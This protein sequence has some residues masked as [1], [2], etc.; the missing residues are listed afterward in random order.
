MAGESRASGWPSLSLPKALLLGLK[1]TVSRRPPESDGTC[2]ANEAFD[3]DN[4]KTTAKPKERPRQPA[5]RVI[6]MQRAA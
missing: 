1:R 6:A 5:P 4:L 3:H 2:H